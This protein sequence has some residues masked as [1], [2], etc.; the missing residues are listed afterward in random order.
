MEQTASIR[1]NGVQGARRWLLGRVGVVLLTVLLTVLLGGCGDPSPATEEQAASGHTEQQH[2]EHAPSQ[3]AHAVHPHPVH[4][5]HQGPLIELGDEAYHAE[6]VVDVPSDSIAI[7]ILDGQAETEVAIDKDAAVI[8]LFVDGVP[9]Q[10]KLVAHT[11]AGDGVQ[12]AS[13][14]DVPLSNRQW[15]SAIGGRGQLRVMINGKSYRGSLPKP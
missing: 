14:F 3:H 13:R 4:G 12:Q 10:I 11:P 1:R 2:P 6:W 5:P 8:N 15:L 7:Y 9:R